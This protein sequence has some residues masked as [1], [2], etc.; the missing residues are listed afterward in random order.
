MRLTTRLS[1]LAVIAGLL[2]LA[3]ALAYGLPEIGSEAFL[4]VTGCGCHATLIEDWQPSMHAK[5]LSDPLF[6]YKRDQANRATDGALGPFCDGCHA[7]I[8]VMSGE[9]ADLSTASEQSLQ[10]VS[11]DFCHQVTGTTDPIGN[12]S[13]IVQADGTK[14]AQYDDA[15]SPA[16]PTEYSAFH[17]SAEF[18]G[19]CHNV[20]HP[21]NGLHLEATYTEWKEG[22]YAAEGIVCQD[23][24]MTAGP[25]VTK[26]YPGTAAAGG[27]QRE[28]VY[29][30]TFVG[31]NVGLG[32]PVLAEERLKAAATLDLTVDPIV[33][34]GEK[35]EITTVITNVGAGHYIPTGLT[36]IRQMWLEVKAVYPDG[37]EDVLGIHEF[38]SVLRD[39]E[40]NAPVD[41]WDAVAFESDD[42]IPPKQSVSDSFEFMMPED[43]EAEIEATLY[44]RSCSE[45]MAEKAGVEIP[46]TTMVAASQTVYGSNDLAAAAKADNGGDGG[47]NALMLGMA[48][49]GLLSAFGIAAFITI[50]GHREVVL[51][52]E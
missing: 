18:C 31:G 52:K 34:P 19:A 46:T 22:P 10:G 37:D 5:A 29:L 4:P 8:A 51:P 7:P 25:G 40:G 21:S 33:A 17:E 30:M 38:G 47:S 49:V 39:A 11:C 27:P 48:I 6:T 1:L 12:T 42:R 13:Q 23:C 45:E 26:P 16:H 28:H 35:A 32:D 24:H 14:R 15:V 41:L 3:P 2:F 36:E 9:D 50:R 43:G 44:Y 20:D